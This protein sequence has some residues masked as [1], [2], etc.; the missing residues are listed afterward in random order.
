MAVDCDPYSI[1]TLQNG[2][3]KHMYRNSLLISAKES[4]G[5]IEPRAYYIT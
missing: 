4:S 5:G 1:E 2:H 3:N